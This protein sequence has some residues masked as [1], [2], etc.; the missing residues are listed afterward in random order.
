M[1]RKQAFV[2]PAI[3]VESGDLREI[4]I[5]CFA[6]FRRID[7]GVEVR[8]LSPCATEPI[9]R[10]GQWSDEV[11]P[12]RVRRECRDLIDGGARLP[13]QRVDRRTEMFGRDLVEVRKPGKIEQW[14]GG[15]SFGRGIHDQGRK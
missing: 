3:G 14:I 6:Q 11:V 10:V 5:E 8:D 1:A 13:D 7:D 4:E 12:G 9:A 15:Q 2:L